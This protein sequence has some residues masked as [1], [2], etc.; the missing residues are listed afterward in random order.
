MRW[1]TPLDEQLG[2][3]RKHI[4]VAEPTCHNQRQTFPAR[5]VDDGQN[6]ELA[7]VVRPRLDKVV[8]PDVPRILRPQP[9]AGPIVEP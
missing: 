3:C 7:S 4:L 5:L 6:A 9:D 2:K 8:G 1:R